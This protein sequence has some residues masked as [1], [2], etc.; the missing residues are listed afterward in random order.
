[1]FISISLWNY[2]LSFNTIIFLS[3]NSGVFYS[4]NR[5]CWGNGNLVAGNIKKGISIFGVS[6]NYVETR[7]YIIQNGALC[8]GVSIPFYHWSEQQDGEDG[9]SFWEF[10]NISS[11]SY[12]SVTINGL[13]YIRLHWYEDHGSWDEDE[14]MVIRG[15]IGS[16]VSLSSN[17]ANGRLPGAICGDFTCKRASNE[18]IGLS[19]VL[20]AGTKK[21]DYNKVARWY[22]TPRVDDRS[23]SWQTFTYIQ[24]GTSVN[25]SSWFGMFTW[26]ASL[27][28]GDFMISCG[29]EFACRNLWIDTS[30]PI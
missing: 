18:Y 1:M 6:G 23:G 29:E 30:K 3:P 20:H 21:G 10:R 9:D 2:F 7:R 4:K 13:T 24:T 14:T 19:I 22:P 26:A 11:S 27:K 28:Y 25:I 17:D 8:S 16:I 12:Y 5:W 15:G